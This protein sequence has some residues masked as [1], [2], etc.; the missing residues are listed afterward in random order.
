MALPTVF[1][2]EDEKKNM[3]RSKILSVLFVSS[4]CAFS[5]S[6]EESYLAP[7][8]KESLLLD[9]AKTNTQ[10]ISVGE[11]G[12]ILLSEDGENWQQQTVP[13][14]STLTAVT[15]IDNQIWAVGHDAVILHKSAAS[16]PW[17]LQMFAPELQKPLL[18]VTFLNSQEG[19]AIGAYGTFLRTTNGGADWKKEVHREFLHPDDIDYLEEIRAEDEDFYQSELA[20]IL[21]HLNK[22]L[23]AGETIYIAG[24]SGLLAKSDDK[25]FT[26]QRMDVNYFGSFFDIQQ[27]NNGDIVAVG[28]RGNIF[29]F[30][31]ESAQWI[32]IRSGMTSSL[33]TIIPYS[34]S[35][36]IAMGNS[37]NIVCVNGDEVQ[38]AHFEDGKAINAALN[39]Q[40]QIII[41]S[42]VGMKSVLYRDDMT[43]CE[44]INS[45]L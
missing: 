11:R 2:N 12:H 13:T 43:V 15:A 35:Q 26:W 25:G 32:Q 6:S 10:I 41:A 24:E 29:K 45:G 18:D 33:N 16:Q 31:S 28:L 37:G 22:I 1:V 5:A 8:A 17:Q 9:V 23:V 20:S 27:L 38:K 39:V 36:F 19:I 14:L 42:A 44:G 34:E 30:S 3:N 4:L 40:N 7:L 21:P